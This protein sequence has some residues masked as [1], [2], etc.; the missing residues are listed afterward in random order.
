MKT[1]P[2]CGALHDKHGTFCSRSCANGRIHSTGTK[3]KIALSLSVSTK[4]KA[5]SDAQLAHLKKIAAKSGA[6][7]K[8][9]T[10]KRMREE[11]TEN[12]SKALIKTLLF[13]EQS[14][15]CLWC[16]LSEWLGKPITLELD[17]ENGDNSDNRRENIRLLCPNCHSQTPTWRRAKS[18]PNW[19]VVSPAGLKPTS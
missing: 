13:E 3:E 17:H 15:K 12:L 9:E 5:P 8:I 16:G 11:P 1:C 10:Q 4:N 14:G 2:K 19:K 18:H 6:A 7:R